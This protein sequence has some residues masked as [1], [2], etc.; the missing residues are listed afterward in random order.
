MENFLFIL[1]GILVGG[2]SGFIGVGGG[3]LVIPSLVL[4]FGF[5][6][7]MAQGTSLAMLL[8]PVGIFAV[9]EYYKHGNINIQVAM[10][11]AIGYLVGAYFG[12]LFT[13]HF[14]NEMMKKIFAIIMLLIS[15]KLLLDK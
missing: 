1:L 15:L 9:M 7:K 5:S 11:L 6:Q 4:F 12:S 8:L 14:S 2:L 13:N 10:F 3:V